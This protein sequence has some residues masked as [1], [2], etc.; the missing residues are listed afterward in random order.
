MPD[1]TYKIIDV[2]G[3]SEDSVQQAVRNALKKAS[4]TIRN[5]DWFE[6]TEVRGL[7]KNN[8]S[9][10]SR[11]A[12]N[13]AS[14]WRGNRLPEDH[15]KQ[16][17]QHHRDSGGFRGQHLARGAQCV[18]K[19]SQTLR[20]IEWSKV[21]GVRGQVKNNS[22]PVSG[23]HYPG[24]P[25]GRP[26]LTRPISRAFCSFRKRISRIASRRRAPIRGQSELAFI[27]VAPPQA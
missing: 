7:V 15:A 14:G 5:I 8:L 20:H 4:Q 19:A 22:E 10:C 3:V 25:P 2:V 24:V 13:W 1:K 21:T 17:L 11:S 6:V 9:P 23:R 26:F 12:L 18:E 27:S 16:Y